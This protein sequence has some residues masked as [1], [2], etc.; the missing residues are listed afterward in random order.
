MC[1]LT[2]GAFVQ[3]IAWYIPPSLVGVPCYVRH[4]F[5]III[6]FDVA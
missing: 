1:F 5:V 3:V 4:N 6:I 2:E